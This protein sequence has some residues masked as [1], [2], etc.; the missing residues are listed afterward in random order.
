MPDFYEYHQDDG[1]WYHQKDAELPGLSLESLTRG[2]YTV[3]DGEIWDT[4]STDPKRGALSATELHV[5]TVDE[6]GNWW[7][8]STTDPSQINTMSKGHISWK[9]VANGS[10]RLPTGQTVNLDNQ[11]FAVTKFNRQLWVRDVQQPRRQDFIHVDV[12]RQTG[13]PKADQRV[14]RNYRPA[15]A[16]E[17]MTYGI[18][19]M[20][21]DRHSGAIQA[22]VDRARQVKGK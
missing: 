10:V 22:L 3:V 4:L 18:A 7:L 17:A 19:G 9:G 11:V 1:L 20:L 15:T 21:A 2:R 16:E 14:P 6:Q 12:D 8:N 13:E 5:L